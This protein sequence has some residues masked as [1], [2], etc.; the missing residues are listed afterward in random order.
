VPLPVRWP[1]PGTTLSDQETLLL[2]GA[3]YVGVRS[4]YFDD[5]LRGAC[6]AGDR[7]VVILGAGL[8]TRAFRMTWTAGVRLFEVDQLA[9]LEFKET[10]LRT[11]RP[12]AR[13]ARSLVAADLRADWATA[14]QVE[15]FEPSAPTAWLAEG[16]LQYLPATAERSLFARIHELS[17]PG[18]HLAV[19]RSAGLAG[20]AEGT[21]GRRLR[22]VSE[23]SGIPLDRLIDTEARLDL[24][25]RL[26]E[27]GWTVTEEPVGVAAARYHRNLADP[28]LPRPS[29]ALAAPAAGGA[30]PVRTSFL[31]ARRT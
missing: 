21:G 28:G 4:R 13:C 22:E 1:D 8:D 7:Q 17:A 11:S 29:L 9:V 24:A 15:G 6:S 30:Q 18:S 23:R 10:V 26:T 25:G 14:L 5:W 16:L 19:E 27:L 3:G 2:Y 31:S 20:M 12:T